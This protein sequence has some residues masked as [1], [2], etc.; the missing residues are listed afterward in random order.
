[1]SHIGEMLSARNEPA[2]WVSDSLAAALRDNSAW[3]DPRVCCKRACPAHSLASKA[4]SWPTE[5]ARRAFSA[6]AGV[7][8][9]C[10]SG[11]GH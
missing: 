11:G 8:Y 1:M 7:D 2:H 10:L 5:A 9:A 3:T 4:C 6:L